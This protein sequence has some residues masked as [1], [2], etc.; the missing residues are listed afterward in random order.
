MTIK[1]SKGN[2]TDITVTV[3]LNDLA[4]QQTVD[5]YADG[6]LL[7]N[8]EAYAIT[9]DEA[10]AGEN[11][12][13]MHYNHGGARRTEAQIQAELDAA[14]GYGDAHT[15]ISDLYGTGIGPK[16]STGV[17]MVGYDSATNEMVIYAADGSELKR[18]PKS[19]YAHMM[20][21]VMKRT[22]NNDSIQFVQSG[23]EL[24]NIWTDMIIKHT[25][26]PEKLA[27]GCDN[28]IQKKLTD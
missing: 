27:V 23:T 22:D 5:I 21:T 10:A 26:Q 11:L 17:N 8:G 28:A 15:D 13:V 2:N 9:A 14:D 24:F 7:P 20:A 19:N 25:Q 6:G 16:H 12:A 1:D 18:T 4:E 3:S